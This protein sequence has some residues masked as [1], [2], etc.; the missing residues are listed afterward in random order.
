[1][2]LKYKIRKDTHAQ[3]SDWKTQDYFFSN[4][5]TKYN[6]CTEN[7]NDKLKPSVKIVFNKPIDKANHK[8][9][10]DKVSSCAPD[11]TPKWT[12]SGWRVDIIPNNE[13]T[14]PQAEALAEKLKLCIADHSKIVVF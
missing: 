10:D 2:S 9:I 11:L 12:N 7:Q 5:P 1:M 4:R 14:F 8:I 13:Y 3:Y 6:S